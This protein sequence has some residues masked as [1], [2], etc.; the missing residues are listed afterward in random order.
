MFGER[1]DRILVDASV[2]EW[3]RSSVALLMDLLRSVVFPEMEDLIESLVLAMDVLMEDVVSD[4][5]WEMEDVMDFRLT[6]F[7]YTISS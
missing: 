5:F 1:W 2:M 4:E 3:S 6:A 7:L